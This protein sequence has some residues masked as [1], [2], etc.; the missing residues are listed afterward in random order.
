MVGWSALNA[1]AEEFFFRGALQRALTPLGAAWAIGVQ[2]AAF[3]LI[4][5]RGFP[6]GWSGV[7]LATIYGLMLGLLRRRA[8]GLFAPWLAHL[9]A[10]VVIVAILLSVATW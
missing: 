3:G 9:A 4:H 8:D 1:V 6:R 2:A 7:A 10:D 5:Y